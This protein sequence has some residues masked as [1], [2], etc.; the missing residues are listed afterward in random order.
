M[1][2][3]ITLENIILRNAFSTGNTPCNTD[4]NHLIIKEISMN[5]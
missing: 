4:E 3:E 1:I 2:Q 5:V